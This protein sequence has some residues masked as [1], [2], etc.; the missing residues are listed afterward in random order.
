MND[1]A[2]DNLNWFWK[3]WF[4]ESWKLDQSVKG[5]KYVKDSAANGALITIENL[6]QIAL[7]VI[8][9]VTEQNGHTQEITLPVD[10]WRRDTEWTFKVNSTSPITSIIVDPNN[11][12]PDINRK[13]NTWTSAQ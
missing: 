5:V 13:N 8:V 3:E 2:G 12:L 10:V 1:A 4:F 9:K 6:Q 11:E 7:P